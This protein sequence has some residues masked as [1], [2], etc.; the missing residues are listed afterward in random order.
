MPLNATN[1]NQPI[2]NSSHQILTTPEE[3]SSSFETQLLRLVQQLQNQAPTNLTPLP[4]VET[5]QTSNSNSADASSSSSSL[6]KIKLGRDVHEVM[7]KFHILPLPVLEELRH[8]RHIKLWFFTN[9]SLERTRLAKEK[10][11]RFN[12]SRVVFNFE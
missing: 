9:N 6:T 7:H 11:G 3:N 8:M 10:T 1:L 12:S 4:N 5:D 2:P